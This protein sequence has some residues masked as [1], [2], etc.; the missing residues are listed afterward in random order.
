MSP[1]YVEKGYFDEKFE[2]LFAHFQHET[3]SAA[4]KSDSVSVPE[5]E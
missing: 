3:K 4:G 2:T 1:N 5:D